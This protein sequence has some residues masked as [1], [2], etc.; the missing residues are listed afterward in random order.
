[1]EVTHPDVLN[2]IKE[3]IGTP[4]A[5][6]RPLQEYGG[7]A[8]TTD[9]HCA[10][11]TDLGLLVFTDKVRGVNSCLLI[12]IDPSSFQL[13][14]SRVY[15]LDVRAPQTIFQEFLQVL[16]GFYFTEKEC[17][18]YPFAM[19]HL[20]DR[21]VNQEE[22]HSVFYNEF[23]VQFGVQ[24]KKHAFL[25]VLDFPSGSFSSRT[26]LLVDFPCKKYYLQVNDGEDSA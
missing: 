7:E 12:G 19:L 8:T 11:Q 24:P 25:T 20:T 1:M 22:I 14:Y 26:T 16:V 5:L 2:I 4:W 18:L 21:E 3:K 10:R 6:K 23:G 9:L 13:D 15:Q 17:H